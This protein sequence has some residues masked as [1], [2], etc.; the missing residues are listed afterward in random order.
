MPA[1]PAWPPKSAPRLF[2]PGRL[3]L[4][5]AVSVEGNQAHYLVRVMRVTPGD[6]VILCDD[7]TGE[8]AARVAEVGK[9]GL[10]VE[11]TP[12]DLVRVTGALTARIG[13]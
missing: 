13:A 12:A 2:V 5:A 9:R 8:W 11:L 6:A 3:A 10:Q 4:G 7:L 1:T